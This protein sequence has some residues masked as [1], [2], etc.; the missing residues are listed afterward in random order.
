MGATVFPAA[1]D[2]GHWRLNYEQSDQRVVSVGF[3]LSTSILT[4]PGLSYQRRH[5]HH[6]HRRRHLPLTH[7]YPFTL[8]RQPTPDR[9]GLSDSP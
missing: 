9:I 8:N 1:H 4:T 7:S 2:G 3:R 6:R 5:H